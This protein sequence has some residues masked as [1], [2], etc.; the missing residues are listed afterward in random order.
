LRCTSEVAIGRRPLADDSGVACRKELV[1]QG[2]MEL[3]R[4][5]NALI[6]IHNRFAGTFSADGAYS[7]AEKGPVDKHTGCGGFPLAE[8]PLPV[9]MYVAPGRYGW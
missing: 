4:M 5:G 6:S 9:E 3:R 1:G 2:I 7:A 8:Q